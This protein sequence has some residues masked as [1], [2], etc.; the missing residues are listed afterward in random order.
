MRA[1]VA[2]P[3][4]IVHVLSSLKMGGQERVALDLAAAQV[5]R[6]HRV[7]ALSI[8]PL[9]HGELAPRFE[10]AGARVLSAPKGEGFDAGLVARLARLFA[11]ERFDVVHTHNPQPLAYA[12]PA[13]RLARATVVHTKH[14]KNPATGRKLWLRRATGHLAH[15]YVAVSEAT[16]EVARANHECSPRRLH[17][18]PNGVDLEA[19]KPDPQGRRA[20]RAE[21]GIPEDAWVVGTVGRVSAEK[22]HPLLVRAAGPLLGPKARLV[23]VGD[24]DEMPAAREAA[25]PFSPWV[26]LTGMRHDVPRLL[27]SF[28]VFALSSRSEGLPLALLEGM[29]SGLAVVSTDVGGVGEVVDRGAAA[30]LV[31]AGDEAALRS[32]LAGLLAS[33]DLTRDLA[34]R[35]RARAAHYAA[36]RVVDAY[37]ALY[38]RAA[39]GREVQ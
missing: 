9:P 4:R 10:A 13:G 19:F 20:A 3:L 14:G 26:T 16:A 18:I 17:V 25:R 7:A 21:L 1:N 39:R 28:D 5:K 33:P 35:A 15:A 23:I 38:T 36:D 24:G 30:R 6:G 8:A 22:D 27:A 37:L 29:A 31:A 12:A 34:A 11:R 2:A 32:A